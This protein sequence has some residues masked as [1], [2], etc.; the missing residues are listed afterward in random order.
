MNLETKKLMEQWEYIQGGLLFID[1]TDPQPEGSVLALA[2]KELKQY[3]FSLSTVQKEALELI[4][5]LKLSEPAS[6]YETLPVSFQILLDKDISYL[7]DDPADFDESYGSA[8]M[9]K[10]Y[11]YVS[12]YLKIHSDLPAAMEAISAGQ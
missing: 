11:R 12:N 2:A 6:P 4:D 9:A 3:I 10:F 8:A 1:E 7:V 5:A